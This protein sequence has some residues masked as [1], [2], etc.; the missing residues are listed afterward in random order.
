M[1]RLCEELELVTFAGA[2]VGASSCPATGRPSGG[3]LPERTR[4]GLGPA[5]GG[6]SACWPRA[7]ELVCVVLGPGGSLGRASAAVPSQRCRPQPA[8]LRAVFSSRRV[9]EP[10]GCWVTSV[11]PL[12]PRYRKLALKWHPDK[13]PDNK[14]EAER[15][16]KQVA[17]AYEVLSDGERPVEGPLAFSPKTGPCACG[18]AG[19]PRCARLPRAARRSPSPGC[20]DGRADKATVRGGRHLACSCR[21]CGTRKGRASSVPGGRSP[22]HSRGGGSGGLPSRLGRRCGAAAGPVLPPG[23]VSRGSPAGPQV[24]S[25]ALGTCGPLVSTAAGLLS[26]AGGGPRDLGS[27]ACGHLQT[28]AEEAPGAEPRLERHSRTACERPRAQ[29]CL[30]LCRG[31]ARPGLAGS[32]RPAPAAGRHLLGVPVGDGTLGPSARWGG[33]VGGVALPPPPRGWGQDPTAG[34][35]AVLQGGGACSRLARSPAP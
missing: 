5:C 14:E 7:S 6:C 17:E 31:C 1:G 25:A 19:A 29:C 32:L 3:S 9:P 27:R 20:E 10:A 22:A 26:P 30:S 8:A 34:R 16:F 15:K 11:R 23:A 24:W 2:G 12:P 28:R 21:I 18:P 33:G 35:A 13:N 4:R